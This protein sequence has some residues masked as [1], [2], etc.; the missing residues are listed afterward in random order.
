MN[1][2]HHDP[3]PSP[4]PRT[5]PSGVQTRREHVNP[6][7]QVSATVGFAVAVVGLILSFVCVGNNNK[8]VTFLSLG[9]AGASVGVDLYSITRKGG[10]NGAT[11]AL[12]VLTLA[13]DSVAITVSLVENSKLI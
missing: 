13:G 10:K 3:T 6:T 11:G 9:V 2:T 7:G 5:P 4:P 12:N 8:D 1:G